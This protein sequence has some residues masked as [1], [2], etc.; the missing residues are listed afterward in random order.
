LLVT[1]ET[2]ET[3]DLGLRTPE[4]RV[5]KGKFQSLQGKLAKRLLQWDDNHMAQG[6]RETIRQWHKNFP[7]MPWVF[8]SYLLA[9]VM[10]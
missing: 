7:L 4:G 8:T 2:F 3:K 1:V 6:G 5:S 10:I 9:C